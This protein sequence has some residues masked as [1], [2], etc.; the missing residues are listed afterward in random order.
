[1]HLESGRIMSNIITELLF[2]RRCPVCDQITSPFGAL[3]C[4]KCIG[5]FQY[6][7]ADYCM[8]C[9]K[10]LSSSEKEFCRDCKKRPHAFERGRSLYRYESTAGAL[11]RFKYKERQEYADFWSEELYAHLG[12]DIASMQAQA[13]VPVPL[14]K[15]RYKTRGYNQAGVLAQALGK[16]C[17][18]EVMEHLVIRVKK[19]VPQKQLNYAERQNNLK[20]AFKLCANDVKLRRMIIIDDI[21]TTGSTVDAVAEI[22]LEGGAEHIFVITLAAGME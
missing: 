10:G 4:S 2:P 17:D 12:N 9:G 7:G 14:H 13:I 8:K 21:Y 15:S 19:T 3:C 1:M 16:R 6:I 22:L 20:K 18:I 5:K 11:F